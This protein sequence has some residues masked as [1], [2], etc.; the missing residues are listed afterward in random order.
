MIA[1]KA[2]L[3][4]PCRRFAALAAIVAISAVAAFP[5]TAGA[6]GDNGGASAV[7]PESVLGATVA[8]VPSDVKIALFFDPAYVGTESG[9]GGEAYN[10]Q[11]TLIDQ[12]FD[13]ST[14]TGVT[15]AEWTAALTGA[16][17]VAVPELENSSALGS[18]LEPGALAALQAYLAAG[19]RLTT[20]VSSAFDFMDL[21]LGLPSDTLSGSESC[22]C[23][24]TAAAVGTEWEAGPDTLDDNNATNTLDVTTAPAGSLA[25]Y[26][27]D[28]DADEAGLAYI[29]VG[30]G[31]IVYFG[32]D[33]FFSSSE[34]DQFPNWF[35]VLSETMLA[36]APVTPVT[37][38]T[39][40]EPVT[41]D[42]VTVTPRFTG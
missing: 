9:G 8:A 22:P 18:D 14:F 11:Q 32:W 25:I 42:P 21:V 7:A 38:V 37:P 2:L 17:V 13:V 33:W 4:M 1:P 5:S 20:Y 23:T 15:T 19:G 26:A 24:K 36:A 16:A 34:T 35:A 39:P 6:S 10:L 28:D 12:G 29:P 41:P 30:S 40:V 3:R 27:D 31:S